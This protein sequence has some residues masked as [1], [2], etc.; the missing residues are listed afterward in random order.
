MLNMNTTLSK[1]IEYSMCRSRPFTL[2]QKTDFFAFSDSRLY[3]L[4][5]SGFLFDLDQSTSVE[6]YKNKNLIKMHT[7]STEII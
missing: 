1:N 6:I 3:I 5:I 7:N 2:I 4:H